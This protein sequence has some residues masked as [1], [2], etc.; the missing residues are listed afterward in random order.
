MYVNMLYRG[1]N[2]AGIDKMKVLDFFGN[3]A[4]NEWTM[5]QPADHHDRDPLPQEIS[6]VRALCPES[7]F[8]VIPVHVD[9]FQE[10]SPCKKRN[11]GSLIALSVFLHALLRN[12][13]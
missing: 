4:K 9:W 12:C 5:I 6:Q 11:C 7:S 10:L 1:V 13:P 2:E 3:P 8:A